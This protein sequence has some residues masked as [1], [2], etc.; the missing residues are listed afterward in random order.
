MNFKETRPIYL[1]IAERICDE[2]LSGEFK[3]EERVTSIRD[4]SALVEVNPNTV[5]RTYDYLQQ[6]EIIFNKR[7]IGYFVSQGAVKMIRRMTVSYTHLRA[8]ET[9]HD[10]VCR[11]LL[12]K[13]KKKLHST[14]KL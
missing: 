9:R 8:H 2:I 7:G 6:Q 12:E 13:K 10:L 1:Q 3:E 11:L 5:M 4:Y 14:K